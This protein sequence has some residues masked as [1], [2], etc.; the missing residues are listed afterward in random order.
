MAETVI[1]LGI[2][3]IILIIFMVI[4]FYLTAV[5]IMICN[6]KKQIFGYIIT[7]LVVFSICYFVGRVL[8]NGVLGWL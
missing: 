4:M 5:G 1:A 7:V 3:T 6:T 8:L 2:G